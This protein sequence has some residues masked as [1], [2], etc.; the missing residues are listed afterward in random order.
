MNAV[1]DRTAVDGRKADL[2]REVRAGRR[3]RGDDERLRRD[4]LIHHH[5]A[6]RLARGVVPG[7]GPLP[8]RR[9]PPTVAAFCPL[10]GEPG[11][12]DLPEV[13]RGLGARVVLPRVRAA[14]TPL[15]WY[16]YTGP[17]ALTRGAYG[18]REPLATTPVDVSSEVDVVLVPALAVGADG[19]RLGQGGGY[20]DRTLADRDGR[21]TVWAV[22]DHEEFLTDVPATPLDLRVDGVVTDRGV[23]TFAGRRHRGRAPHHH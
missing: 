17:E 4:R 11:G 16:T 8:S 19:A 23:T 18:I 21:G 3:T 14:G 5:L 12:H 9:T 13:L 7:A 10:P 1:N 20:Y 22:V 15:E 2:R 6:D